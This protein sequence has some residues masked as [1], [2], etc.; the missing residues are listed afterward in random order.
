MHPTL[1]LYVQSSF[2]KGKQKQEIHDNFLCRLPPPQAACVS[3]KSKH[4]ESE[5]RAARLDERLREAERRAVDVR[6]VLTLRRIDGPVTSIYFSVSAFT[7]T[8]V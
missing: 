4:E 2:P 8:T 3:M 5:R 6:S 1:L 7:S